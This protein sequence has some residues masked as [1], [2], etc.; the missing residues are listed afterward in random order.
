MAPEQP[1]GDKLC[2]QG[3]GT[4]ACGGAALLVIHVYTRMHMH[5]PPPQDL[6]THDS[7][8]ADRKHYLLS[9]RNTQTPHCYEFYESETLKIPHTCVCILFSFLFIVHHPWL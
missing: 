7:I 4:S 2:L 9:A 6:G 5:P 3:K 8:R 1:A